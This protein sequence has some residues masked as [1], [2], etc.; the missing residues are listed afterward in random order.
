MKSEWYVSENYDDSN[1]FD[2]YKTQVA[3]LEKMSGKKGIKK[4]L[5]IGIGSGFLRRYLES[6]GKNVYSIDYYKKLRPDK[7]V[8][9]SKSFDLKKKFDVVLC[10]QVLEHVE[11]EKVDNS[12]Q[13]IK[14]H[15]DWFLFSIP[16]KSW[17]LNINIKIPFTPHALS[18]I[19]YVEKGKNKTTNERAWELGQKGH[20]LKWFSE[21]L[22]K[23]EFKVIEAEVYP[24]DPLHAYFICKKK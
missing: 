2:V 12:L 23:N 9:I 11:E 24:T 13:N 14:E 10:L 16:I 5:E 20:T 19:F 3:C 8:D 17:F 7:V 6:K 21:K 18:K 1:R 4:I 22:K 15:G